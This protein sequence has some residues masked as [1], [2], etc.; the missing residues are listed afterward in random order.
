M[1]TFITDVRPG[2]TNILTSI[3]YSRL[4]VTSLE[5]EVLSSLPAPQQGW[6][7]QTLNAEAERLIPLTR[8]GADAYLGHHWVGSTEV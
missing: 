7:T 8:W 6:T 5:G 2:E 1:I 4:L 3:R